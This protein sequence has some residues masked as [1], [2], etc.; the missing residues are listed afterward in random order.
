MTPA[1]IP[2]LFFIIVYHVYNK[3]LGMH[4]HLLNVHPYLYITTC[5]GGPEINGN[6]K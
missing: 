5:V 2:F 3:K 4:L 6:Q 1:V